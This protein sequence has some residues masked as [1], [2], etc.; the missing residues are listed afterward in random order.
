M[1][2]STT[3]VAGAISKVIE[4]HGMSKLSLVLTA[5]GG[6]F[7]STN[8]VVSVS[9]DGVTYLDIDSIALQTGTIKGAVYGAGLK[10]TTVVIDPALFP[11][12]KVTTS[13]G[14][15]SVTEKLYYVAAS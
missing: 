14:V 7:N 10:S 4:M 9:E 1:G 5:T 11:Y 12:V 13:A 6:N 2:T 8:M 15:G 3:A